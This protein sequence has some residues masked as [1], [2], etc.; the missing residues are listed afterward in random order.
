[1]G[2]RLQGKVVM[3]TGSTQGIGQGI[4]EVCAGEGAQVVVSGR[5]AEQGQSVVDGIVNKGGQAIF[6]RCD[7]TSEADVE[8][9]VQLAVD[10]FG[11]FHGLVT[12]ASG[13]ASWT[14]KSPSRHASELTLESWEETIRTDLTGTFLPVKHALR[15]MAKGTGGSIVTVSSHMAMEGVG[16]NDAY[17]AA[18]GGVISLTRTVASYYSRYDIRCNCLAV[19]FVESGPSVASVKQNAEQYDV[20]Y[21][22]SLGR[23]GRPDD[24]GYAC[25]YLLADESE[26]M[27]GAIIPIDGGSYASAH[28]PYSVDLPGYARKRPVSPA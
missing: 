11:G 1:M 27:S 18:K 12:N 21:Q 13:Y 24:I 9:A 16:G 19:G 15:A 4:A 3:V 17:A 10:T 28:M 22:H 7:V 23:T 25:A 20:H 2:D 8:A 5:R 26:Y 6:A 14:E